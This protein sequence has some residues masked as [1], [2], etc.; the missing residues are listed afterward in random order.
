MSRKPNL[1]IIG[2]QKCGTT[3]LHHYLAAHPEIFLSE[4]KEPGYFVP[5]IDYYPR[6]R[7]WYLG[8]FEGAGNRRW[9]GESSTHYTKLPVFQGVVERIADFVDEAP[10]F[11][12][13]MRDPVERAVSHYWHDLRKFHEHR[14]IEEAFRERVDY[15][16]FSDYPMQLAPYFERFGRDSVYTLTFEEM[17]RSPEPIV[18]SILEWL[19]LEPGLP[20]GSF[21]RLNARPEEIQRVRGKGRLDRVARSGLWG[22]VSPLA[23]QALKDVAKRFTYRAADPAEERTDAARAWLRPDRVR[24]P[25]GGCWGATSGRGTTLADEPV[26]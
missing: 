1:F 4:P 16:A 5:E 9:V 10:R 13:L 6:D 14:P 8:L 7:E 15:R 23:P 18:R 26:R 19:G 22:R 2:A 17:V 21:E 12:Y 25:S 11:I 24:S 3:S 20:A